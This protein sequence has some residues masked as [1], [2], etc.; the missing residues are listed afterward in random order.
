MLW[1]PAT[2]RN[3]SSTWSS[4][5]WLMLFMR[6]MVSPMRCTS[7]GARCLKTSLAC[8]SPSDIS[9]MAAFSMPWSSMVLV[10]C[11]AALAADPFLDDLRHR[12]RVLLREGA[13]ALQLLV[14]PAARPA[15]AGRCAP[16]SA[17]STS[18][19]ATTSSW[20]PTGLG[21]AGMAALSAGRIS[22]NTTTSATSGQR[23]RRGGG[24]QQVQQ[25]GLLVDRDRFHLGRRLDAEG[26]VDDPHRVAALLVEAQALLHQR[27]DLLQFLGRQRRAGGLALGVGAG[28]GG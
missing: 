3:L 5:S 18:L 22:L 19:S 27:G 11:Q 14:R 12:G 10:L 13:R 6:A 7:F 20:P 23:Q 24:A 2:A 1:S 16:G 15:P 21:S 26:R 9:R 8:S 28:C 4:R 25:P 17:A